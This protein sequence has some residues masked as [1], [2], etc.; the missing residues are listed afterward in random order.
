MYHTKPKVLLNQWC[1]RNEQLLDA[2]SLKE[3]GKTQD[4]KAL[5]D[6]VHL[7]SFKKDIPPLQIRRSKRYPRSKAFVQRLSE[8]QTVR[9]VRDYFRR[10]PITQDLKSRDAYIITDDVY[11]ECVK[12]QSQATRRHNNEHESA[13]EWVITD[14]GN[15]G[16]YSDL[17]DNEHALCISTTWQQSSFARARGVHLDAATHDITGKNVVMYT[18]ITQ[19]GVVSPF[20]Y[21]ITNLSTTY[22]YPGPQRDWNHH[23]RLQFDGGKTNAA[24]MGQSYQHKVLPVHGM[25]LV[26]G[27]APYPVSG[28]LQEI[29]K[30][31]RGGPPKGVLGPLSRGYIPMG[32]VDTMDTNNYVE[33]WHNQLKSVYLN[34]YPTR[35]LDTLIHKLVEEINVDLQYELN[36]LC[37]KGRYICEQRNKA[38]I[39][40]ENMAGM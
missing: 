10:F 13:K 23:H 31:A 22:M 15:F 40:V 39:A 3:D 1:T 36:R 30:R 28:R 9:A 27:I 16:Y 35:R 6:I 7:S 25:Y 20:A 2:T 8:G 34:R 11:N 29:R 12:L 19:H 14:E 24:C 37:K 5:K 4:K 38:K 32:G 18:I 33:T 21:L 17:D 26:H